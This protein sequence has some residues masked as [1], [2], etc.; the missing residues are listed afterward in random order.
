MALRNFPYW[1]TS[2]N[3]TQIRMVTS[4]AKMTLRPVLLSH[5]QVSLHMPFSLLQLKSGYV[6]HRRFRHGKLQTSITVYQPAGHDVC[7]R[8]P[9]SLLSY[10]LSCCILRCRHAVRKSL[11]VWLA[12]TG[13]PLSRI[14]KL[15]RTSMVLSRRHQGEQ[16]RHGQH[17][18]A[19]ISNYLKME[20]SHSRGYVPPRY[21]IHWNS[22]ARQEA[23]M[24][25]RKTICTTDISFPQ[26][27]SLPLINGVYILK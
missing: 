17:L 20:S 15:Y 1:P 5:M 21:I 11:I 19:Y 4:T 26:G 9:R 25:R 2:L 23:C 8:S 18:W 16:L 3:A 22:P 6:H 13:S 10:W 27:R 12:A 14:D 7:R 24:P